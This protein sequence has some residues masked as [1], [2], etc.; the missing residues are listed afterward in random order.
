MSLFIFSLL[1]GFLLYQAVSLIQ[2]IAG[3]RN[4]QVGRRIV[5]HLPP[6]TYLAW[7]AGIIALA[8]VVFV[9]VATI[10]IAQPFH[11]AQ[12]YA[13]RFVDALTSPRMASAVF[14]G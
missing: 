9:L 8:I 14:G 12:G 2:P 11:P 4:Y 10:I 3:T 5:V 1:A 7:K 13:Y 6:Q